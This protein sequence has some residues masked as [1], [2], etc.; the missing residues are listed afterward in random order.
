MPA[1]ESRHRQPRLKEHTLKLKR[2]ASGYILVIALVIIGYA[3]G[4]WNLL[5][6]VIALVATILIHSLLVILKAVRH[7][8][9][10]KTQYDS[11]IADGYSRRDALLQISRIN[12]PELDE[13]TQN[14]MVDK[15]EAEKLR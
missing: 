4:F 3:F 5:G 9:S 8:A 14:E 12:H 7:S 6:V 13:K 11:M 10:S 2:S 15:L 1:V